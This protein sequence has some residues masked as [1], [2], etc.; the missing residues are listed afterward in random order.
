[1]P[2][3]RQ[4]P[5]GVALGFGVLLFAAG[6]VVIATLTGG[7][8]GKPSDQIPPAILWLCGLLFVSAG[9]ALLL[10]HALPRL[11]GAC[12]LAALLAFT[13]I[14]NWI[15][16][17]PG[18]RHFTTGTRTGGGT[19]AVTRQQPATETGGR[20]VFG[21]FA[22]GLDLLLAFGLY[23]VLAYRRAARRPGDGR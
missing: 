23:K 4:I 6:A 3:S 2:V 19:A 16:F 5:L 22:G 18:E 1:M 13:A 15:A 10:L 8:P 11:S 14:F 12:A 7:L 21:L 9:A 20:V 17:A